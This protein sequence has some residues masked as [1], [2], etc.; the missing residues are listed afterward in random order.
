MCANLCECAKLTDDRMIGVCAPQGEEEEE[1]A[2]SEN[3][4]AIL[5]YPNIVNPLPPFFAIASRDERRRRE[6]IHRRPYLSIFYN[7]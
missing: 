2:I 7:Q 6:K 3:G 1:E 4:F 5:S